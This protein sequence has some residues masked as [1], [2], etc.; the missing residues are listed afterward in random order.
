MRVLG[1]LVVATLAGAVAG[2]V[3]RA[4]PV[5][6]AHPV[7]L[8]RVATESCGLPHAFEPSFRAA[9][10]RARVPLPLLVAVARVESNLRTA[11]RSRAGGEGLLQV[12]PSTAAALRLDARRRDSN[13]LAGARYLRSLLDRFQSADL[14]LAA[15]NAGPTAVARAGGAP[16]G[17]TLTYVANVT[18]LWRSLARCG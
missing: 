12:R 1:L 3:A 8:V 13:V 15:Y 14:A 9:A 2:T 6:H 4:T 16:T 5:G 7:A 17:A 10:R 18:R 11:A